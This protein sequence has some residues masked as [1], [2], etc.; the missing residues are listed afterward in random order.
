MQFTDSLTYKW[1]A[2]EAVINQFGWLVTYGSIP[3]YNNHEVLE[4][5]FGIKYH[6]NSEMI[7]LGS[8]YFTDYYG[9]AAWQYPTHYENEDYVVGRYPD[10]TSQAGFYSW[11]WIQE[12]VTHNGGGSHL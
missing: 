6:L 9:F 5:I 7:E 8:N 1:K 10:S 2:S 4:G 12:S 11:L 3:I